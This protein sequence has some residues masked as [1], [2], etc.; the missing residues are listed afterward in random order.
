MSNSQPFSDHKIRQTI[1]QIKAQGQSVTPWA[2]QSRLGGGD[3]SRIQQLI[4]QFYPHINQ[5]PSPGAVPVMQ[6]NA[7]QQ[8]AAA[9]QDSD[10]I[11]KQMPADI[12]A[13]MYQMQTTVGQM[14]NQ[15][16]ND[17]A[18]NA[19]NQM[20]GKLFSA[21]QAHAEA[22]QAHVEAE[23]AKGKMQQTISKLTAEL[24]VLEVEHKSSQA[25]LEQER[26]VRQ[27]TEIQRDDLLQNV[28]ALQ[29]ENQTLEQ[30]AF[31]ANIQAAKA[32]GLAE[33]VKEQL[34]LAK[35]SEKQMQ[36]TLDR[37]EK[38][39][40]G[41]H[42]ELHSASQSLRDQMRDRQ[43]PLYPKTPPKDAATQL[44]AQYPAQEL[45][46]PSAASTEFAA[47]V[48]PTSQPRVA[49]PG[50]SIQDLGHSLIMTRAKKVAQDKTRSLSDK[51]FDRKKRQSKTRNK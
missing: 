51:L 32:E 39:V 12:E 7:A 26:Q 24:D 42:H 50:N 1:E 11:D 18:S 22:Q 28:E 46:Q 31:N 2:V 49:N 10:I 44:Q 5:Q 27:Q 23:V 4:D 40:N 15:L 36:K 25:D 14:A 33:I 41:L 34:A 37:S 47:V 16:W 8:T 48:A 38:K 3:F 30:T 9:A 45:P 21:Q 6:F 35:Q 43:V 17:A 20:R 13:S 29:Q 19:E